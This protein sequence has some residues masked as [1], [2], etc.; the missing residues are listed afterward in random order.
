MRK[1]ALTLPSELPL[2]ELEFRWTLKFSKNDYRGQNPLDWKKNYIIEN[3]R[4]RKC[5]KQARMTC[6]DIWNTSYGQRKVQESNWQFN[7][8]PLKV[9]NCPD[10]LACRWRVTYCWKALDECYNFA[11]NL[12]SIGGL[13]TKLWGPKFVEIPILGISRLSRQNVI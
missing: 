5:L 13:H 2:G 7:S 11:L 10:F 9:K 1:W 6:L 8:Q 4:K 3:L 12:I